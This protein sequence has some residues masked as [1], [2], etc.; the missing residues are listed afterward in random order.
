MQIP[1]NIRVTNVAGK[2]TAFLSP[3]ADGLKDCYA[4]TRL[5]G[6]STLEF[7][8][9]ANS[10]KVNE[11]TPECELWANNRVYNLRKDDAIDTIRDD[12]NS[13]WTKV[14]AVE[15]WSE[16]DTSY[17]EPSISNDPT[18]RPPADLAV[19][20][21]GGGGNL[22]GNRYA[23]GTAGHALYAVL[24]G[25]GW[26]LGTVDVTGVRDLEV[27]KASRLSIIKQIQNIWDGYLVWDSV[28]RIVHLRDAVKWNNY[29]GFQVRYR[30]N[31]K[32]ITRTQSNRI[33]TKL[34]GFGHDDL[35][36]SNV[37]GGKKY[38][39]NNSYT[40]REYVGMYK[41]QDIYD[42]NE[43]KE[44]A[45]A[46]LKLICR[47]RYLYK[48]KIVDLRILPEYSHEQYE[49][50]DMVGIVDPDIASDSPRPRL[51]RHKYNLFKPWDCELDMG[52]PEE[53]LIEQLKA[54]FNTTGFVDGKFNG[55][56]QMSG[57]YL[58]DMTIGNAKIRNLEANKITT[59][60]AKI[61]TAQIVDLEVGG[62]VKMGPNATISWGKVTDQPN[63]GQISLDKINAT[64]IDKDG[65]WTPNVYATNISTLK[66]KIHTAQIV[67]LTV[68]GNVTMGPDAAISWAKVES[69]PDDLA[70]TGDIPDDDY[71][72]TITKNTITTGSLKTNISQ[73]DSYL[74][75]GDYSASGS[76]IVLQGGGSTSLISSNSYGMEIS[77]FN[78]LD[79]DANDVRISASHN[80][81]LDGHYNYIGSSSSWKNEIATLGDMPSLDD[82]IEE[83]AISAYY[84]GNRFYLD[85]ASSGNKIAVR[86]K[87]GDYLGDLI[88]E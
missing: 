43:L 42:Q 3:K 63:I 45:I 70:Y 17:I 26:T 83:G 34:Y 6:E 9:P 79:I 52:D 22:S 74:S 12:K 71:I 51:I 38:V 40:P 86:D 28:N 46:E 13:L 64:Y 30:K 19:I 66:G 15:R 69:K 72:T 62:N 58:E 29:T 80:V 41:N 68:G 47:P 44:K 39:T 11:L 53:R 27:E 49:L 59:Q 4:D 87:Y 56:G 31:L 20:I 21:V 1:K 73:V 88:I 8:L 37:N 2:P 67:D 84:S 65:I 16:L 50:G 25:S 60:F 35:D 32:H 75:V 33:V 5:N 55:N 82:I 85:I 54:S 78:D 57:G 61:Q 10:E 24:Q 7:V 23:T 77:A 14:M 81:I 48:I 36:I 18:A 76:T